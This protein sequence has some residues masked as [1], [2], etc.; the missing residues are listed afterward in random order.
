M[1]AED[2][3]LTVTA[4]ILLRRIRKRR[5]KR[6]HRKQWVRAVFKE[7]EEKG[8]KREDFIIQILVFFYNFC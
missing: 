6:K 3:E 2:F 4:I 8:A 5:F 1:D 7:R